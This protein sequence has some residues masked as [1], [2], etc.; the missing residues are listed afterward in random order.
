[1]TNEQEM[2]RLAAVVEHLHASMV[3]RLKGI[4]DVGLLAL[5]TMALLSG[6]AIVALFTLLGHTDG[7][8][9]H[10][11]SLWL[12]F[13]CFT[14]SLVAVI[15]AI[16]FSYLAQT[17]NVKLDE[18]A[19]F[20]MHGMMMGH[21]ELGPVEPKDVKLVNWTTYWAMGF[22]LL[23]L[24]LFAVGGALALGAVQVRAAGPAGAVTRQVAG[25]PAHGHR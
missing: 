25:P 9:L 17:L 13:V 3:V 4:F 12:S 22:L 19:V 23:S 16:V 7:L 6:G 18:R 20:H 5:K 24:L 1:M 11:T 21:S 8:T 15:M 14:T 10:S 2:A